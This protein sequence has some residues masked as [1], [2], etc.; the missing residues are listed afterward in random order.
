MQ[1]P[2]P[3]CDLIGLSLKA[4]GIRGKMRMSCQMYQIPCVRD[5]SLSGA[6]GQMGPCFVFNRFLIEA[7]N[8]LMGQNHFYIIGQKRDS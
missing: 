6:R 3:Y 5:I 7:E 1:P 8:A 2:A 4:M